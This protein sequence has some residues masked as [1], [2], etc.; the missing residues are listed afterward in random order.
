M[1]IRKYFKLS[2]S[3]SMTY[4][5]L[6]DAAKAAIKEKLK[7]LNTYFGSEER[8]QTN[9]LAF[10]LKKLGKE[11]TKSKASRIM[12][13]IKIEVEISEMENRK[14]VESINEAKS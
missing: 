13:T 14:A 12:E 6:W 7:A 10:C 8:S 9:N 4:Q 1:E 5:N 2:K 11:E 3:Q